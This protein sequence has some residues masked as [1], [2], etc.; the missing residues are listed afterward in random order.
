[1]QRRRLSLLLIAALLL[2]F[3]V[4]AEEDEAP[5]NQTAV[6]SITTR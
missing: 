4:S 1:M 3:T 2:P 6:S 5:A